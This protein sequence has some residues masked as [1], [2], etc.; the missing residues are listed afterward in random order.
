MT[1]LPVVVADSPLGI[2]IQN[3]RETPRGT[4]IWAYMW[5]AD[6]EELPHWHD[7]VPCERAA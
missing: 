6:E 7:I 3:G 4:A 2:V 5:A 1:S